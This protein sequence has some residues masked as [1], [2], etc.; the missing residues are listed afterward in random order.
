MTT[1]ADGDPISAVAF[2]SGSSTRIRLLSIL[3]RAG[4][5]SKDEIRASVDASRTTVQRNLTALEERGW[6][7]SSNRD[8]EITTAG[9][10]IEEDLSTLVDTVRDARRLGPVLEL[11]DTTTFDFDPRRV[12]FEVTTP[13]P[14]NPMKM[15]Q[16]HTRA[17]RRA[18][19]IRVLLP[20]TGVR[21]MRAGHERTTDDGV[22]LT[23]IVSDTVLDVFRSEPEFRE[24]FEDKMAADECSI[25][26]TDADVP[27]YLGILDEEVQIGISENGRPRALLTTDSSDVFE[28]AER[29][30]TEYKADARPMAEE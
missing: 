27:Y 24:Y 22:P 25:L 23:M 28:W 10:W 6:I 7:T 21:A 12:D 14:G 1:D 13:E 19:D 20:E 9:E 17:L 15:V 30:F 8:Y 26:V 11:I 16:E 2:L 18:D 5:L 4:R 29:T 3:A